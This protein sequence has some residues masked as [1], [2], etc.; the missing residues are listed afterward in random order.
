M[1]ISGIHLNK[2]PNSRDNKKDDA[3]P[4]DDKGS[5]QVGHGQGVL[6]SHHCCVSIATIEEDG[7]VV[8]ALAKEEVDDV[9]VPQEARGNV[10]GA[11][12]QLDNVGNGGTG[13]CEGAVRRLIGEEKKQEKKPE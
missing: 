12:A 1:H 8:D 9:V 6:A 3:D 5:E 11:M 2:L 13:V 4:V 7:V 10:N